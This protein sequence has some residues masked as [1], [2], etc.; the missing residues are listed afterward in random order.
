MESLKFSTSN[1]KHASTK[2]RDNEELV[3]FAIKINPNSFKYA[4]KKLRENK[5]FVKKALSICHCVIEHVSYEFK[6]DRNIMMDCIKKDGLCLKFASEELQND[7]EFVIEAI[8]NNGYSLIYA[9]EFQKNQKDIIMKAIKSEK[10][11]CRTH[12]LLI[13]HNE[14]ITYEEYERHDHN[15][16]DLSSTD[17][18]TD[19]NF[20]KI[21]KKNQNDY[22][23]A[24]ELI[25]N[26][27]VGLDFFGEILRS[28]YEL[29]YLSLSKKLSNY[30]YIPKKLK[31]RKY[32]KPM[33]LFNDHGDLR[34]LNAYLKPRRE[35]EFHF[36][37]IHFDLVI[38]F[39]V[40]S[41]KRKYVNE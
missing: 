3:L 30:R 39:D 23:V 21:M 13:S 9:S 22:D 29:I 18:V 1:L 2:L 15:S 12:N 31:L 35:A 37:D 17:E 26:N 36:K 14:I 32:F 34:K 7:R 27:I 19:Y 4:S 20:E 10:T 38:C 8:T 24:K 11:K 40:L 33:G 5:N 25:K 16:D 6:A 41:N 28:N